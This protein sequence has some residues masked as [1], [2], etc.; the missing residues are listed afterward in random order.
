MLRYFTRSACVRPRVVCLLR[1]VTAPV[2]CDAS[3]VSAL[4]NADEVGVGGGG[5]LVSVRISEE[6]DTR[7]T[8]HP[9]RKT[10]VSNYNWL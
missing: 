8:M 9:N 7:V 4:L 5:G 3:L 10:P 6:T 2:L 1:A